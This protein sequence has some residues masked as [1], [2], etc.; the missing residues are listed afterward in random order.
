MV[1]RLASEL[2]PEELIEVCGGTSSDWRILMNT[3]A[4]KPSKDVAEDEK[5]IQMNPLALNASGLQSRGLPKWTWTRANPESVEI[6]CNIVCTCYKCGRP[7]DVMIPAQ[8]IMCLCRTELRSFF[9]P[10][11]SEGP[12]IPRHTG[13]ASLLGTSVLDT[14]P[15]SVG[16]DQPP[17]A[18]PP[19]LLPAPP[20]LANPGSHSQNNVPR[21]KT[22]GSA[23]VQHGEH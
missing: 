7:W 18:S 11:A 1:S 17:P 2:T 8:P 9:D 23:G 19:P 14:P 4:D 13:A 12:N 10:A 16:P 5:Q 22:K 3:D 20:A 21:K 6:S 15:L